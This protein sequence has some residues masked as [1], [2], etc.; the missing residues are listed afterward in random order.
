MTVGEQIRAAD[1]ALYE[2]FR[3][4]RLFHYLVPA[5]HREEKEK[6]LDAWGSREV[7]NPLF[8]YNPLPED[9]PEKKRFL[10]DLSLG[11]SP[12][13]QALLGLRDELLLSLEMAE[14]RGTPDLTEKSARLYGVPSPELIAEAEAILKETAQAKDDS[15]E[16]GVKI[17]GE[18]LREKLRDDRIEGWD[19]LID[20][21]GIFLAE[22]DSTSHKI[23]LREGMI[24][25]E[26]MVQR[27]LHHIV[28]VHVYRAANAERQSLKVFSLGLNGYLETEEALALELEERYGLFSPYVKRRYAARVIA[29][30]DLHQQSFFDIFCQLEKLFPTEEAYFLTE[31][32]KQGLTHTSK[33]GG[34]VRDHIYLQG[35][36]RLAN[37][38]ST[39]LRLLY[40]GKV[41]F[42]HLPLVKTMI[43]EHKLVDPAFFP[44]VFDD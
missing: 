31:R 9:W 14:S 37:I 12:L 15:T 39:D 38:N 25:S 36:R 28:E 35:K 32:C 21:L 3:P 8:E 19:V 10:K 1:N 27:L 40:T 16:V 44:S 6:F 11:D 7:Y 42:S 43:S 18:R 26:E 5:N 2:T 22:A 34:F 4:F 20:P 13:E 30:R 17:L 29:C 24:V 41:A 23:R 33:P